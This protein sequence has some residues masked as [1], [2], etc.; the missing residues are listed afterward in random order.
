[1]RKSLLAMMALLSAAQAEVCPEIGPC[2]TEQGMNQLVSSGR[3]KVDHTTV[4]GETRVAGL[5]EAE[6][7]DFQ[8][9]QVSGNF[10][11][12]RL[13]IHG[14]T[15]VAGLLNADEVIF[16]DVVTLSGEKAVLKTCQLTSMR[17][18]KSRTN[19]PQQL[20]LTDTVIKGNV[21]FEQGNGQLWLSGNARV[22]GQL[23]GGKVYYGHP[24]SN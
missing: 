6:D 15:T 22:E 1:M 13:H 21:E 18:R 19:T 3:V 24:V 8:S 14:T 20:V 23:V 5:L 4:S 17:I 7:S 10:Q 16:D 11:A 9:V 2:R 12:K